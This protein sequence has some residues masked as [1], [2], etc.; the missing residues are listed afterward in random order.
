MKFEPL[1]F[2]TDMMRYPFS[3]VARRYSSLL[4]GLVA[5]SQGANAAGFLWEWVKYSTSGLTSWQ[6]TRDL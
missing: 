3:Q 1:T 4:A 6:R 5:L 2:Y